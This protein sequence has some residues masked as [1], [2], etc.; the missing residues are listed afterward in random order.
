MVHIYLRNKHETTSF[1]TYLTLHRRDENGNNPTPLCHRIKMADVII[2]AK[3]A[4]LTLKPEIIHLRNPHF[5][6]K[7]D[8]HGTSIKQC[9]FYRFRQ[10]LPKVLR[11]KQNSH[12]TDYF[13]PKPAL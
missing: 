2:F 7:Q 8:T 4:M 11:Q 9:F 13:I 3:S 12:K 1:S 6:I 10:S 5:I